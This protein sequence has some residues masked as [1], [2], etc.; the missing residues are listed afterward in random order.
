[1]TLVVHRIRA[2][3]DGDR[4]DLPIRLNLNESAYPP[5]PAVAAALHRQVGTAHR[6]PQ[7]LPDAPRAAIAAHLGVEPDRVT[8]GAGATGVAAAILHAAAHRARARGHPRPTLTTA[9]P[10]F[11]GYPML[12]EMAGLTVVPVALRTSGGV[13]LAALAAAVRPDTAAVVVCSPHNPT[14]AV[15]DERELHTFLDRIPATVTVVLDEAYVEFSSRP[16]DLHELLR[17][18]PRLLV[19]RTFSKAY[20]LAGLRIGYAVG[21]P[22][23]VAD[24]RRFEVPFSVG[25]AARVAVPIA[26]AAAREM[27]D[28]VEAMRVERD[29][30][31]C[32]LAAIGAPPPASEGNFLYLPGRDGIA[33]GHL[34][35]ACGIVTKQCP[36][37]GV[38]VTVGDRWSTDYLLAAL[39]TMAMTA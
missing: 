15:V 18:H 36:P 3:A 29:R 34:L 27:A 21:P 10:T 25:P 16:P 13:D 9:M 37:Y 17:R 19:L 38:R 14:G 7:F 35:G 26:L 5:L 33:L 8:V 24:A 20:G 32:G 23:A 22:A 4:G 12:A 1:M 2:A 30:M 11:D 28:R 31:A 39:R 6:Y